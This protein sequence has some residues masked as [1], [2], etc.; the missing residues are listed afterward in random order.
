MPASVLVL[1]YA[2][3]DEGGW[4]DVLGPCALLVELGNGDGRRPQVTSKGFLGI[5]L[6]DWDVMI[7]ESCRFNRRQLQ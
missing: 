7:H 4:A 5:S 3:D 1:C 2:V 6:D